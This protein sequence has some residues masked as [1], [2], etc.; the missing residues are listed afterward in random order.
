MFFERVGIIFSSNY[1]KHLIY[2]VFPSKSINTN[3]CTIIGS[4]AL[5]VLLLEQFFSF[6][7][8][9]FESNEKI[10]NQWEHIGDK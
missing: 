10:N 7:K 1:A 6:V 2:N 4:H 9:K 5:H 8:K 3:V